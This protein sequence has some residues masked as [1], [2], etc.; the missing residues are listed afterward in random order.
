M[1]R[2]ELELRG[3]CKDCSTRMVLEKDGKLPRHKLPRTFFTW[4]DGYLRS[5]S[6]VED[7]NGVAVKV[8]R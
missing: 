7:E 3:S 2:R 4:C 1:P 5:P 6:R 8:G